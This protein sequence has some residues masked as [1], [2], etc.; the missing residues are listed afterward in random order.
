[1]AK[2]WRGQNGERIWSAA[3]S[4]GEEPYSI[5]MT[6]RETGEM[7]ADTKIL[8][9]D[10]SRDA[11]ARAREASYGSHRL[12]DLSPPH[13]QRFFEYRPGSDEFHVRDCISSMVH[14]AR[15]NLMS[16]WPFSRRFDAIFCRNVM[17]YFP[18]TICARLVTRLAEVLA[19]GGHLFLGAAESMLTDS[20]LLEHVE[21]SVYRRV[22]Q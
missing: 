5:A 1:L 14:F 20:R 6:L 17:I 2:G 18:P 11:L 7:P 19:P 13:K 4:T 16:D 3:C 9:S 8:A 22:V 15:L 10:I 12:A 21:H